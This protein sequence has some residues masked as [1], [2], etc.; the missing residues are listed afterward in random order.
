MTETTAQE[1]RIEINRVLP[2]TRERI[3]QAWTEVELFVQWYGTDPARTT[4]DARPGGKWRGVLVYEGQ[5][6]TFSG[7]FVELVAPSRV[8]LT[9]TDRSDGSGP[10]ALITVVL[11]EAEGGTNV[12]FT[13]VGP[14]PEEYLE[15]TT[16]GWHS[17]LDELAK[18]TG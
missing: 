9:L 4:L 16:Q 10:H 1:T 5:E 12:Q 7:E 14:L 3:Y 15:A 13:Q 6:M 11:T 17:Y 2:G 8:A 18:V